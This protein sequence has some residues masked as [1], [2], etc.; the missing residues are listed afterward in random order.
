[1]GSSSGA[2]WENTECEG[3]RKTPANNKVPKT[4]NEENVLP[5]LINPFLQCWRCFGFIIL[6]E[7]ELMESGYILSVLS[8]ELFSLKR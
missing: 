1:M 5:S 3:S 2:F 8:K 4:E 6:F 7:M